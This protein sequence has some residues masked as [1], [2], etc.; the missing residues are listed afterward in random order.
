MKLAHLSLIAVLVLPS[1]SWAQTKPFPVPN[2]GP[3]ILKK[4]QPACQ[5]FLDADELDGAYRAGR[6][7]QIQSMWMR[8]GDPIVDE[9]ERHCIM[10]R[11][12]TAV[13]VAERVTEYECLRHKGQVTRHCYWTRNVSG[14]PRARTPV[15]DG[16]V[17]LLD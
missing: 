15:Y 12:G 2:P 9:R 5:N 7:D 6:R 4:D 17:Y 13:T 1:P 16:G 14:T 10:L 8:F 3:H 11:K